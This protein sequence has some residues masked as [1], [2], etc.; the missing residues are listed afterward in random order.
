MYTAGQFA[1]IFRVSKKTL[2]HYHDIGLLVP[3]RVESSNGY[4]YYDQ[5]QVDKMKKILYLRA[6]HMPLYNI[7]YLLET[8]DVDWSNKIHDQLIRIRSEQRSL[9]RIETELISIEDKLK[10]GKD[11]FSFIEQKAEFNIRVFYLEKPIYIIGRAARIVHGSP[12][13]W[14]MVES[15][16]SDYFGD[17]VPSIIPNRKVPTMRF[18]ICAEFTPETREFTYMMGDQVEKQ[19]ENDYLP[20]STRSYEIP[21]GHYACITLSALNTE[22]L[23]GPVLE[24]GYG[25][26]FEWL[27]KTEDWVSPTGGAIAYEV[28]DD[29]RF[30]VPSW[31]E[32]NIWTPVKKIN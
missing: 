15:I 1:G 3:E 29:E 8:S 14:P 18:G 2:R 21:S 32:M 12:E 27:G 13:H 24:E 17:D 10:M 20:T 23:T 31:P 28:Y 9:N 4:S 5:S 30:E 25:K 19:V 16:I 6:L 11:L 26:L 22:A 7:K